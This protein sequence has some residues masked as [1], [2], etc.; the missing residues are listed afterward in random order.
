MQQVAGVVA[1]IQDYLGILSDE[2]T[3]LRERGLEHGFA[4]G[5][6]AIDIGAS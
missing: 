5:A 2:Y 6:P 3:A 1:D 4:I